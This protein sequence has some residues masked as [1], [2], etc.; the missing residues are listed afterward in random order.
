[1]SLLIA[2]KF[3][4]RLCFQS[5]VCATGAVSDVCVQFPAPAFLL[6]EAFYEKLNPIDRMDIVVVELHKKQEMSPIKYVK[7][8]T[9]S[10]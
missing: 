1:M 2:N 7:L 4:R 10:N 5:C 6:K 3:T 9:D 8:C